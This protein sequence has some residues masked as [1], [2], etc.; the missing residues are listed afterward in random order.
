MSWR[1]AM[2][3]LIPYVKDL[4]YTHL[5][6]MGVAEHP[7]D[8]S[9]GYQVTGYFAPTAR[10][11]SAQDLMA[12]ID[13]CHQ[14]G[15]GVILDWV[16]GHFP[17]DEYGLSYFDGTALY[18]HQDTRLGEHLEWGTKVFNYGRHEVRNFLVANALYWMD[19]FHVDGLR[20]DAVASMLYLDYNRK[21]GEWLP[22]RHGG[23]EN[24][25]AI[26]F[27]RQMNNRVHFE[28]PGALM[29][30]EESTAFG[31]VTLPPEHGGLGFNFKW[32][33][34]WMNDTLRYIELDPVY[35]R[36]NHH[37]I[38][39]SFVYAWSENFILPISHDE[40]VHGKRSLLDKMPGDVWQKR[41]NLRLLLA[42]MTAH[43]GKKLMF[44]GS[45]FG[46][47][48][49]WRDY[50]QLDWAILEDAAHRGLQDLVRDLNRLYSAAAQFH[51]SDCD[52][53]GFR[54]VELHN[55]D[56]S[57]WAFER[58]STGND[59]GAPYTCLFNA[60]PV[61]RDQYAF[62]VG[63]A[64]EYRKVLDSDDHRYGGSGYNRQSVAY[65]SAVQHH[66]NPFT[67]KLDLPP[68]GAMFFLGPH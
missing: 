68:L 24:L 13:A 56:D 14:A 50:E 19:R 43:P 64:G 3:Q 1:E 10:Y 67:L 22:N 18:E 36:F 54:W 20:V 7:L 5:E 53:E 16:P 46:Q 45:E 37:L 38:T 33:M 62:G 60:T 59:A 27:L 51:G 4:G 42:F 48:R 15:I 49:E 61:P 28:F 39:F 34:G 47:W 2:E 8:A 12:F 21:A 55:A 23:R 57:V 31:G 17:R 44:M 29:I 11:G 58:R 9:W 40:V 35:R 25:E 63:V 65:T 41:A 26:E 6:L 66:G 30:A 32:N 52:H